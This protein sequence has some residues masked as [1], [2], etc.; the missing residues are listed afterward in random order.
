[1]IWGYDP[2]MED[3]YPY[4][5]EMARSLLAQTGYA[6]GLELTILTT[7]YEPYMKTAQVLKEQWKKV[8]VEQD[9]GSSLRRYRDHNMWNANHDLW[10]GGW[11]W[12]Y[13]DILWWYWDTIRVP[14]S[15]NR[16]WWGNAYSDKVI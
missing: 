5:P 7:D 9:R 10:A 11:A 8:G 4:D 15:S 2:A 12:H 16:F 6:R 14:P 13:A 3:M 1:M